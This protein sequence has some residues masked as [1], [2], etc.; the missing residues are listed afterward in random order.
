MIIQL[1]RNNFKRKE[2]GFIW[3]RFYLVRVSPGPGFTWS[4]LY[5]V[6]VLPGPGLTWS[7]IYLVR[8]LPGPGF[9]W[10]GFYL[11]RV[12]PGTGFTWSRFYLV[13]VPLF[14]LQMISKGSMGSIQFSPSFSFYGAP[15]NNHHKNMICF[16]HQ[17][18]CLP[19]G[20]L[21][22]WCISLIQ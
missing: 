22:R 17:V 20:S 18:S 9:T 21:F 7:G 2:K 15:I 5:L 8:V 19:F 11:V 4:G 1:G 6:L 16:S 12:L 14:V 10:Y 3:S 13:R